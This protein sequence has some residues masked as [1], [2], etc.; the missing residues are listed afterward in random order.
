MTKTEFNKY[1]EIGR[2]FKH[3]DLLEG[4][5]HYRRLELVLQ[6]LKKSKKDLLVLDAACGDG[7][8]AEKIIN[9][10]RVVGIDISPTRVKRAKNR[11]SKGTFMEGDLYNL[12]FKC[13]MFDIAVLS[14][15][16]EHLHKPREV[17]KEVN[18]VL[19]SDGYLIVDIP[20]KSNIVDMILR[21]FGKNPL[22]GLYI[23]ESHIAFYDMNSLKNIFKDSDFEILDIRGA[24]CIRYDLPILGKFTWRK[25]WH[26][27][28]KT[29]DILIGSIPII[30]KYGAIQVFY[31]KV[32]K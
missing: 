5:H 28:L 24:P 31:A 26:I 14:E 13:N 23:D 29:V 17:L 15:I 7:I 10:H 22:W 9:Y 8:Q 6:F 4:Y 1:E 20:S 16:I 11:I 21:F 25:K 30:K 27:V 12:P 2:K 32:N 19:K 3:S 18:R